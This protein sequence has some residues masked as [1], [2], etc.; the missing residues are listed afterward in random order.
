M[1][2]VIVVDPHFLTFTLP[3]TA[4]C[5]WKSCKLLPLLFLG[6]IKRK[7]LSKK[8]FNISINFVELS[9]LWK[10]SVS[11][12]LSLFGLQTPAW[13]HSKIRGIVEAICM[14]SNKFPLKLVCWEENIIFNFLKRLKLLNIGQYVDKRAALQA[15]Q[16][17]KMIHGWFR[18]AAGW[19]SVEVAELPPKGIF[20]NPLGLPSLKSSQ[21][22]Y[23]YAI[24]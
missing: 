14:M 21:R 23:C 12:H 19:N 11:V 17:L 4:C 9:F 20:L 24:F 18:C 10:V 6:N 13:C 2:R 1:T 7:G 22:K 16:L 15:G 5:V 8:A 3:I